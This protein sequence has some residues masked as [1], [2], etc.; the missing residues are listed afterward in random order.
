MTCFNGLSP[1]THWK[2]LIHPTRLFNIIR[3]CFNSLTICTMQK[4]GLSY[5]SGVL[6][7]PLASE[8]RMLLQSRNFCEFCEFELF[9][10]MSISQNFPL[11][12]FIFAKVYSLKLWLFCKSFQWIWWWTIFVIF[13]L[14][15]CSSFSYS[16][17]IQ[18]WVLWDYLYFLKNS[19]QINSFIRKILSQ[20]YLTISLF[21]KVHI[22]N[23]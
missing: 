14:I 22:T 3:Q 4:Q 19:I 13:E 8:W 23:F 11:F 12:F 15:I 2:I 17:K 5:F 6:L 1:R 21:V 16:Y 18:I 20:E 7:N 9:L 10:R